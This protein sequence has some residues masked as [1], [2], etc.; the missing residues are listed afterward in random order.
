MPSS[1]DE[2]FEDS[3]SGDFTK[4]PPL[5][6]IPF[7]DFRKSK[8][9]RRE[10]VIRFYENALHA[11]Q[12]CFIFHFFFYVRCYY[13]IYFLYLLYSAVLTRVASFFAE[14]TKASW[15]G[16]RIVGDDKTGFHGMVDLG[17][18]SHTLRRIHKELRKIEYS[19][20]AYTYW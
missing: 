19:T 8:E 6:Q 7:I 18:Q 16:P 11:Y 5:S 13:V 14:C 12:V 4:S 17:V 2:G 15:Q 9:N 20:S 1:A 10:Q 3:R